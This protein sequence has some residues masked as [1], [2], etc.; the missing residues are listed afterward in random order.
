METPPSCMARIRKWGRQAHGAKSRTSR[1]QIEV[2]HVVATGGGGKRETGTGP[3]KE[4]HTERLQLAETNWGY[5]GGFP[6]E[7]LWDVSEEW[8][9]RKYRNIV[10]EGV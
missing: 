7:F 9:A 6:R 3:S 4:H 1:R 2:I 10:T 5:V 8:R